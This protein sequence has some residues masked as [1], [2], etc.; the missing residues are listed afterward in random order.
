MYRGHHELWSTDTSPKCRVSRRRRTE[1]TNGYHS[2]ATRCPL[3]SPS[4]DTL[5]AGDAWLDAAQQVDTR[6]QT[7]PNQLFYYLFK[8]G[9]PKTKTVSARL[10]LAASEPPLL[11][12]A[13][14]SP[15][16]GRPFFL[17]WVFSSAPCCC[18]R[19]SRLRFPL[20]CLLLFG[21]VAF[22]FSLASV[23]SPLMLAWFYGL[24][25]HWNVFV[26]P[27]FHICSL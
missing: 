23:V 26:L 9:L 25:F 21:F 4:S 18:L 24:W 8:K 1:H 7:R 14:I 6:I 13:S 20:C 2:G 5:D 17:F 3:P 27:L 22:G 11:L 12:A 15:F 19:F 10:L 16:A